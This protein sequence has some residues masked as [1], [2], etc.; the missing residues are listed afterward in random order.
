MASS[1]ELLELFS[2]LKTSLRS[3]HSLGVTFRFKQI[4]KQ[5]GTTET[6]PQPPWA[7]LLLGWPGA[8]ECVLEALSPPGAGPEARVPTTVGPCAGF[9]AGKQFCQET[10]GPQSR[11]WLLDTSTSSQRCTILGWVQAPWWMGSLVHRTRAPGNLSRN[12]FSWRSRGLRWKPPV[13]G[14]GR[15]QCGERRNLLANRIVST[16]DVQTCMRVKS[17]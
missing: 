9:L 13:C 17:L 4:S 10:R 1:L 3:C 5:N 15:V 12:V 2:P 8:G 6:Q 14:R 11:A 7:W 16:T